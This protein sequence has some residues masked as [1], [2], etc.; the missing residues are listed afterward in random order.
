METL[1]R[2]TA[3]P[4]KT[5]EKIEMIHATERQ[6]RNKIPIYS[7]NAGTQELIRIEF[8]FTAGMYQQQLPLQAATVNT[9]LE[10]G[11]SKMTAAQIAD[12]VDYFGAFLET[13]V[14]QDHASV[15][16]YTL[17]K[18]LKSTL[19][20]IEQVIKDALFPQEELETHLQT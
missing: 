11:T 5:V 8:M 16:L 17:N 1:D 19:P 13:G 15:V 7:V 9:M 14:S 12:A 10:E 6:L 4:F 2:K 3:P 18:H 20:V